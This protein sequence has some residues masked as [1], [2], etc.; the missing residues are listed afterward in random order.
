MKKCPEEYFTIIMRRFMMRIACMLA[1]KTDCHA[2][3]TVSESVAQVA[4]RTQLSLSVA[5]M[6]LQLNLFPSFIGMDK[7]EIITISR[8][9]K[10]LIFQFQP[11]ED[12]C[13]VFTP[14]SQNP[15]SA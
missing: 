14:A 9:L 5:Q 11:F 12:C 4:S 1:E 6:Q 8:K 13:T 10:P 7:E 2:L 3:I 15:S